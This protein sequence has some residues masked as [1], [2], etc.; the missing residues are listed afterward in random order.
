MN[1][2]S[3]H[4]ELLDNYRA[5]INS[6]IRIK[7]PEIAQ[8]VND[9][10]ENNKLWLEPLIQFNPTFEKGQALKSLVESN[11]L[12]P[13]MEKIF[14]NYDLY[15]HQKEAIELGISGNEFVVTSGTG[16][17]KSLTYIATIFNH[18]L[19]L[20]SEADNKIQAVIVY[21]MNALIN[22]QFDEI[23]K[24]AKDYEKKNPGKVFPITFG[25]YTGQEKEDE[26]QKLR[27]NPPHI[28][29][30]NYVMLEYLMTRGGEDVH[31]RRNILND[32]RFLV[33]DELHTYRG[34]QG[35]DVS[36]LIRRIKSQ[37]KNRVTCIGTSATMVSGDGT[38]IAE[39]RKVVAQIASTIFGTEIQ[40]NQ[41]INE[42]LVRSL[43]QSTTPE[44]ED[45]IHAMKFGI[46][47]NANHSELEK[48]ATANWLE[49]NIALEQKEGQYVR[50]KPTTF[51]GIV[52]LLEA[53][54]QM[55]RM[56]CEG[57]ITALLSWANYLNANKP[58]G[59]RKNYLPYRIHQFISQTG[60]VYATLGSQH[61]REFQL[62]A[63]LYAEGEKSY[64]Y[65]LVFSRESGHEFY[66]VLLDDRKAKILP[67]EFN[68]VSD[69]EDE[70][71][72]QEGYI[73]I[74]HSEDDELIWDEQR[75]IPELPDSWFNPPK[76][77]GTRK[78]KGNYQARIPRKIF[79]TRDGDFSFE[80]PLQYEGWFISKPLALDPSSGKIFSDRSEWG[81][82]A[83]LGGEGRS[84]ATTVLSFE[85]VN[86]L[87]KFNQSED[88]QKLLSFTD[89]RQDASLQAGHFNDFIKVGQLRAAI[90]SAVHTHGTMDYS[91]IREKVFDSLNLQQEE[92]ARNPA[93]FPGPKKENEDAFKD[94]IMYRILHDLRRSWRVVL[95]NLEQCGLLR[96][97]YKYLDE[98]AVS[99]MH[100]QKSPFF[101]ALSSEQR[102]SFIFQL[103][104]Y[105]RKAYALSFS[106]LE[107]G[108]I[109][110]NS[111]TI[112]EKLKRPWTIDDTEK[113][114]YPNYIR[115][116]KLSGFDAMYTE[117]A[118][119]AGSFG[120]YVR[121]F[122][123]QHG[124]PLQGK[125]DYQDFIYA[126]FDFLENAGWLSSKVVKNE[127]K[128]N[129]K[130][131]QLKVDNILWDAGNEEMLVP[132]LIRDRSYKG[133]KQH[134][135]YYFRRFYS[136]NFRES[137]SIE[138][139][140]HTGQINSD[141][142]KEREADFKKG[143]LSALFCSPTMEL[144]VDISD[145]SIVHMR[146]VPPSPANYAQRS[147]RAGRSGQAALVMV[148]C[149]NYSAHDRYYYKNATKMVAGSVSAP[150]L[151]LINQELLSSHLNGMILTRKSL[152][153]L[154]NS[155]GDLFDKDDENNLPLRA[156]IVESL[157]LSDADKKQIHNDFSRVI[158]DAYFKAE[159]ASRKPSWFND[160]WIEGQISN[161]LLN[162]D[163]SLNRWRDL[164]RSALTQFNAANEVIQNKIYGETHD[165]VREA[166]SSR[167]SAERQMDQLLNRNTSGKN[168]A[169]AKKNDQSEFY[170]YRYLAS[171]GF[172]PGY[173]FTRLPLRVIL[174][175]ENSGGEF[176]SRPRYVAL[177]EF[178]PRNVIYHDGAK[179]RVDKI[180]LNEAEAKLEKAK[181]SPFTGYIMMKDQFNYQV[182][183]I[184]NQE[185]NAGMDD[186]IHVDFV[187]M[188]EAR[189][190]ELQ[191]I[192]CQEE[193]RS[194]RGF[195]INTYFSLDSG[196]ESTTEAQVNL[197]DHLLLHIHSMPSTRLVHVNFK[198]KSSSE[199]GYA[200]HL[201]NGRWQSRKDE[202]DEAK[203]DDIRRVKLYTTTTANTLYI[204]P[205]GTLGLEGGSAG[206][207]TLMFALKRAIEQ[208]FQV[209]S[210]EIGVASVGAEDNPN[211]L[212]YES[213]EGSL[214]VLSQI[215]ERP[216]AYRAVMNEA[217]NLCFLKDGIEVPDD[218]LTPASY[219][220]LLSYYNQVYHHI[221]DR[222]LIRSALKRL[223]DS[224]I[225][226]IEN[227][228][229]DSY[230]DQ[231]QKLQA[232][233]DQSSSTEDDFL[234]YL[235]KHGLKLPDEAQPQ[236]QNM[237]VKPD[238]F[239]KPNVA[240]FCD[241]KPHDDLVTKMEDE[242]KRKAL[243]TSGYQVISW[244][245]KDKLDDVVARRP[246]IFKRVKI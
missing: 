217:F 70:D 135:N 109:N 236:I 137:K 21:P 89:N 112:K 97:N 91:T 141:R 208:V 36:L 228:S 205:V 77:D 193:E 184:T 180:I 54:T 196:F 207:I 139:A 86:L 244:Y 28:F 242:E 186:Q 171:E 170:P 221:I 105:F 48:H 6:F 173:N 131:Y 149:S 183:P 87:R 150:K 98:T 146:N 7:S 159:I 160:E 185:L 13:E 67:L 168:S 38:S 127:Q 230:E 121:N 216:E 235:K 113:I 80:H 177:G 190:Y 224:S 119:Y 102:V 143:K 60:T 84:T 62:E 9:G 147:G 40:W 69:E 11:L 95:P 165:K 94:Y 26:R 63:G 187:E 74:Q 64:L 151:D 195:Q 92:Y 237:Y 191:R 12:H 227:K 72:V 226:V 210:N 238:F 27:E 16:S 5:Y 204:Q 189:A 85:T 55:P 101:H 134:V 200:L 118:S 61:N 211:I 198:W 129:V 93:T 99:D 15:R 57:H 206:T 52:D 110:K 199:S 162:F 152:N 59:V 133:R 47:Q 219:D 45:L 30:T 46:D 194:R 122:A 17:G 209:E 114:E 31:I 188:P 75:D 42:Y 174:E 246:D 90:N 202:N 215:V 142:R 96:I 231:Y 175:N 107:P 106:M 10:L 132:D 33:F 35:A 225:T 124:F 20:G 192:T 68:G 128:S 50:R 43:S 58:E 14:S 71:L 8:F 82:L 234:K 166:K 108:A 126:L 164:Y 104:E 103:F 163:R 24:F 161:F 232:A 179:Y 214:G 245:Y 51:N 88:K 240:V 66:S 138:G 218:E 239:Y 22:S 181:I 201:K 120:R 56:D 53:T 23:A 32:I 153:S 136:I 197:G 49:A 182:D 3:F 243:K 144:G 154:K 222:R 39:Q 233:R 81:K 65:P 1:I 158:S 2:L 78:L 37:A 115:V 140:E 169:E 145:L 76:R 213:S 41:V 123:N 157:K 125:Q 130:V 155:L 223:M 18:V 4:K 44:R 167:R 117:S 25:Q 212:I 19:R 100:W 73:F 148:Y 220:D 111:L 229:F 79:F 156:E 29:L 34:R 203:S 172:L 241:G 83:R 116:E 176:V 178:G